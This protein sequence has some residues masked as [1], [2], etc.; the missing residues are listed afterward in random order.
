MAVGLVREC[1]R[2]H[3]CVSTVNQLYNHRAN[4]FRFFL[5]PETGGKT[6]EEVDFIFQKT[7]FI[8]KTEDIKH[9]DDERRKS[10]QI[11]TNAYY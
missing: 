3:L 8:F 10:E 6:L 1:H 11:E 4:E 2:D 7:A 9:Q 5:C